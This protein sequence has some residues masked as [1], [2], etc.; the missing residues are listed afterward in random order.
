MG[1]N[2]EKENKVPNEVES[3]S[4]SKVALEN[5]LEKSKDYL[6]RSQSEEG[7]WSY[8]KNGG[9]SLETTAWCSLALQESLSDH[10][11]DHLI[12]NTIRFLLKTQNKDGGW[13]TAPQ[14][15]FS[16]WVSGPVMLS[17]RSFDKAD[18]QLRKDNKFKDAVDRG[19]LRLVASRAYFYPPV[20]NLLVFLSKGPKELQYSRGWPW[21]PGCFHWVEPTSYHL[22][23][24]KVPGMPTHAA[25]KEIIKFAEMFLL[26]HPCKGGGWNHGN[27]VSLGAILP[28]YR[29]TTGEALL[30]LQ[31]REGHKSIQ[32]SIKYLRTLSNE[33][34]S[35][36]GLAWSAL[37]LNAHGQPCSREIAYLLERQ[38]K[39]NDG[40]F[41]S[42]NMVNGL[43][44]MA[45]NAAATNRNLLKVSS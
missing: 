30:A 27:D 39:R 32:T 6:K 13:P 20:A 16:D 26:E 18:P 2:T 1:T 24:F 38:K 3:A 31:G 4:Y 36:M 28:P 14:A 19:I 37:A 23:A 33:D 34:S 10:R 22:M 9:A 35:A 7:W 41:D 15:G 40:S 21:D 29:V 5:A 17:L 45:I 43:S 42:N 44:C 8:K 25:S 11:E 12:R